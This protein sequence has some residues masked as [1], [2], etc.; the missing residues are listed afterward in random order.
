MKTEGSRGTKRKIALAAVCVGAVLCVLTFLFIEAVKQQLWEQSVETIMESTQQGCTTLRVQ[1]QDDIDSIRNIADYVSGYTMEQKE[2][3]RHTV[4][5]YADIE[6]GVSLYLKDGGDIRSDVPADSAAAEALR[7]SDKEEGVINPHIS[8]VTG[9]NVFDVFV[10]VTLKDGAEGY[11]LKEY[12]V[13]SIV[14][15]F[16]LSFYNNAG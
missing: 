9:V 12:E 6:G 7:A 3:I 2:D 8:S 4:Q 13:E 10:K 1:L 15:S 16:S 5:S 11:F 14:D